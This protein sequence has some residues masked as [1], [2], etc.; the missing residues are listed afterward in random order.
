MSNPFVIQWKSKSNGRAGRGS[1]VFNREDA[2]R[3]V[4]ELNAEYP[5]ID[6]EV[7]PAKLETAGEI[8]APGAGTEPPPSSPHDPQSVVTE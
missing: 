6:H 5:E 4:L 1:K 7:V 8:P 3:L 2:D